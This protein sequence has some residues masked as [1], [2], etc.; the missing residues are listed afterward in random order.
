MF[1]CMYTH[2]NLHAV[3]YLKFTYIYSIHNAF[4]TSISN[5]AE[6]SFSHVK[7]VNNDGANTIVHVVLVCYVGLL[8][9]PNWLTSF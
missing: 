3:E 5:W 7:L 2:C 4:L 8:R 9:R 1:Y 6:S